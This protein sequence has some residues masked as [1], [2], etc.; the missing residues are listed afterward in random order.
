MLEF[1]DKWRTQDP[2]LHITVAT[3]LPEGLLQGELQQRGINFFNLEFDS[4]LL[5]QLIEGID[6][7]FRTFRNNAQAILTLGKIIDEFQP[8]LVITNTIM[9]PWAALAAKTRGIPHVWFA[10]EF[11]AGHEFEMTV[12]KTF[13]DIGKL[14]DLVVASSQ[15]LGNYLSRWI[16]LEKIIVSYPL[17]DF[18]IFERA[19]DV[20]AFPL[21]A[22]EIGIES[23]LTAAVVGKFSSLKGQWDLVEA[24]RLLAQKGHVLN[25]TFIGRFDSAD[26]F[27]V[28]EFVKKHS[29]DSII[30]F[31]G[32]IANPFV[33]YLNSDLGVVPSA[34]EGFGRVTVEMLF[35]G[36][37]VIGA[38]AGATAE[39]ISSGKT[40][41]LYDAQNTQAMADSIELYFEDKDLLI[42]QG[43]AAKEY[44]ASEIFLR[45]SFDSVEA[46]IRAIAKHAKSKLPRDLHI[47]EYWKNVKLIAEDYLKLVSEPLASK[48]SRE[49]IVGSKLVGP[50]T[51]H[52]GK[53]SERRQ[54]GLTPSEIHNDEAEMKFQALADAQDFEHLLEVPAATDELIRCRIAIAEEIRKSLTWKVGAAAVRARRKVRANFKM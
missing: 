28:L 49:W 14:S 39:L 12:E 25:M 1:M 2:K 48:Q 52:L 45:H 34:S 50:L 8:D 27:R 19:A 5:P 42:S 33:E 22:G 35:A 51:P 13:E 21:R 54:S 32:E 31:T 9:A 46:K 44:V 38:N 16:P 37:P 26:E 11:G 30:R 53:K 43:R 40:G 36:L 24:S 17:P 20:Q 3:R 10:H 6:N 29:P 41:Q 15:A 47:I 7:K 23:S 18:E 4:W